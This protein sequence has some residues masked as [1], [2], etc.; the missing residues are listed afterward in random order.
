MTKPQMPWDGISPAAIQKIALGALAGAAVVAVLAVDISMH[1]STDEASSE[2]VVASTTTTTTAASP[3]TT[4]TAA[5]ANECGTRRTVT[6]EADT[7]VRWELVRESDSGTTACPRVS[8]Y[9]DSKQVSSVQL[10]AGGAYEDGDQGL[11]TFVEGAEPKAAD[12]TVPNTDLSR[13]WVIARTTDGK[14][15]SAKLSDGQLSLG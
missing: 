11:W 12:Q 4:A 5:A 7:A 2:A 13:V 3:T 9:R 6:V 8:L 15:V 10:P 14:T 1:S